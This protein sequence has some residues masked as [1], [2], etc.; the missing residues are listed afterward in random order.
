M[1]KKFFVFL[2]LGALLLVGAGCLAENQNGNTNANANANVAPEPAKTTISFLV[3]TGDKLKYCN[4]ADMASEEF[5]K[6]ITKTLT[7]DVPLA[8]LSGDELI[9]Q[10][11]IAAS[12]K[13]SLTNIVDQ[14]NDFLKIAGDTAYL[15]PIDGWAGVSI[16]LCAWKPLVEVNLL[17]FSEIKKV[18]WVEDQQK[19]QEL[20][21]TLGEAEAK[22]IAEKS[23]IKGGEALGGGTYNENTKTWWFDA[24]LNAT[25]EGCNPACVV[26]EETKKAEINWRC[27][28][29][30]PP[31][32]GQE[33]VE[34]TVLQGPTCPVERIPP[35]PNCADKPYI[36]ATVT[37][38]NVSGDEYTGKT[39]ADGK[40]RVVVP[41]GSYTVT[42]A[43]I[44]ILPR[45]EEKQD[46]AVEAGKFTNL[47]I[48]C[49][50]GIR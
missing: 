30:I 40:F 39:G 4:G 33:G 26:S 9:K 15:A 23:C 37:A 22:T 24:N 31:T 2:S 10:S 29:L 48:S 41:A 6:T 21:P 45:C 25:R 34:G 27:T 46:V 7:K 3:S 16:F 49:D 5:G 38:K 18:V 19:W 44:N 43:P 50:T 17:N 12:G 32:D 28:G 20:M 1:N 14:G 36:G 47:E 11:I 13:E 35:D 8:D 42:V